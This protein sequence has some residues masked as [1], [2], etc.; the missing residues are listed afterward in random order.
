M[1]DFSVEINLTL[2]Q[3]EVYKARKAHNLSAY[4]VRGNSLGKHAMGCYVTIAPLESP[5][6]T[7]KFVIAYSSFQDGSTRPFN[8][9]P[10]L[11]EYESLD[12]ECC[13]KSVPPSNSQIQHDQLINSFLAANAA[14]YA[15]DTSHSIHRQAFVVRA[16]R[17]VCHFSR[18]VGLMNGMKDRPPFRLTKL[19]RYSQVIELLLA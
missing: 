12:T 14:Q 2:R 10:A 3:F 6:R 13:H 15:I 17:K 19:C 5:S 8:N 11:G 9:N 7:L 1:L 16:M 4:I 18:S